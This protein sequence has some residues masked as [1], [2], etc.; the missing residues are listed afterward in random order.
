MQIPDDQTIFMTRPE[1]LA[2]ILALDET[3]KQLWSAGEMQAMWCHQ[4][5]APVDLD[6][7]TVVSVKATELRKSPALAAFAGKTF[8]QVLSHPAPAFE[9]LQ[10]IKEFA[11]QTLKDS[12]ERQLREVAR[13]LYYAAYAAALIRCGKGLG[14]MSGE[15]LLPGFDWALNQPWIDTTTRLLFEQAKPLVATPIV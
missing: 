15:E 11:K 3:G 1:G 13:A 4:L 5:S 14:S 6:L 12:E 8:G 10:L 2:R 7:D 9:L